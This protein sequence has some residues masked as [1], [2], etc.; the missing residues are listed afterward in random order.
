M[1]H[2]P[3]QTTEKGN[4][5]IK[6]AFWNSAEAYHCKCSVNSFPNKPSI[7]IH[8]I[9][10]KCIGTNMAKITGALS[11]VQEIIVMFFQ[12]LKLLASKFL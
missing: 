7:K 5:N 9:N 4:K 6:K 1:V 3:L 12:M 10:I 8:P 2:V 11:S